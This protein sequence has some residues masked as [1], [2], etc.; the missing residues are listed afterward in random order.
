MYKLIPSQ[1]SFFIILHFG[2]DKCNIDSFIPV[3]AT[4][5]WKTASVRYDAVIHEEGV[6]VVPDGPRVLWN[7]DLCQVFP[8][9]L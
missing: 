4:V 2:F 1:Q 9:D 5:L 8:K 7:L 6:M 3:G